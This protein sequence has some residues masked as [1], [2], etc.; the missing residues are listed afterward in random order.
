VFYVL[1]LS[2]LQVLSVDDDEEFIKY[3]HAMLGQK[4]NGFF[5]ANAND[6]EISEVLKQTNVSVV[7][8]VVL[9]AAVASWKCDPWQAMFSLQKGRQM[10]PQANR[11]FEDAQMQAARAL[12]AEKNRIDEEKSAELERIAEAHRAELERQDQLWQRQQAQLR[13]HE[14]QRD[15]EEEMRRNR[16]RED[17]RRE[18]E[19]R[20]NQQREEDERRDEEARRREFADVLDAEEMLRNEETTCYI[21]GDR[22]NIYLNTRRDGGQFLTFCPSNW[23]DRHARNK[24]HGI[25]LVMFNPRLFDQRYLH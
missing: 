14:A 1:T 4:V 11:K 5:I 15:F 10:R 8:R 23:D 9:K 12:A 19:T 16:E 24:L 7:H 22:F 20:R 2:A 17:D 21:C 18:E 6:D 13:A 25:D 3:S